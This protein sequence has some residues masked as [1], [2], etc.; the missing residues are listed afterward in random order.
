MARIELAQLVS[1]A[2]PGTTLRL[3]GDYYLS[4]P[5]TIDK[6]LNLDGNGAERCTITGEAPGWLLMFMGSGSWTVSGVT[7][8]HDGAEPA[9]I[10]RV[11]GGEFC[12]R[13]CVF[14]GGVRSQATANGIGL[15]VTGMARAIVERCKLSGDY[16]GVSFRDN[17]VGLVASCACNGNR[18]FGAQVLDFAKVDLI[19]N[20]CSQN[21]AT[22]MVFGGEAQI[23]ARGNR[24]NAN[25]HH[26][27]SVQD[28]FIVD[29]SDNVCDSNHI[30]GML[31]TTT[32]RVKTRA[33]RCCDN[34]QYGCF[35]QSDTEADMVDNVCSGNGLDGIVYSECAGGIARANLCLGNQRHGLWIVQDAHPELEGNLGAVVWEHDAVP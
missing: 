27:M 17:T 28:Y 3:A 9:D 35:I 21:E 34:G 33:N 31:F 15:D 19:D 10:V 8:Q 30:T 16:A 7:F 25:L 32:N 24:C 23:T 12:A 2:K 11:T 4:A 1:M 20:D 13:D 29:L 18:G 6:P 22:G 5:L 26:G 14:T